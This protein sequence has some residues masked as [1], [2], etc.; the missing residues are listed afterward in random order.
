MNSCAQTLLG[1][2]S[3]TG[4]SLSVDSSNLSAAIR[5]L[6]SPLFIVNTSQGL[7]LA[8]GGTA[9]FG[10]AGHDPNQYPIM[11]VVPPIQLE[12]LGD[13]SFRHDHGLRFNYVSGAMAAGIGSE[14]IVEEMARHGMLGFFGSAGLS[15]SRV[16]S[17]IDR[18]E[19]LSGSYGFNLIHSPNEQSLEQS[20]VD[21]YLRRQVH[22]VEASAYLDLTPHV[23]RYRLHGIHR[24]QD[25]EVRTPNRVVAKVSRIEVGSKFFAP[26]PAKIL[27]YLVDQGQITVEQAKLAEQVPVA[28]DITAEADSGGHTDNRPA[29]TLLPTILAL[30][31]RAAAQY[32]FSQPLRVGA[33]GGISTPVSAAA[34]FAM[35]AAYILVGSVQQACVESGTCDAVRQMLAEAEQADVTMCPCADMFEMGVKVQVLKRGT[36]FPM[37]AAKLYETYRSCKGIE[38]IPAADRDWLEKNL[39]RT[40]LDDVWRQTIDYFSTRDPVQIEKG[41][42][43]SKHRMALV[44]RWYLGQ[45]SRWANSG[46][47]SRRLDYQI[48][49][50]PAMGAFNEW[51]RGTF[52]AQPANRSVATVAYNLLRG[53]AVAQRLNSLRTQG[54][55]VP[56][57]V[58]R[59]VPEE[60][61]NW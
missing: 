18:L 6:D 48:W 55:D 1:W 12:R 11:G 33:A 25:G 29:L 61:G 30:R 19:T 20:I 34:A 49:C 9:T 8:R 39:F 47:A 13:P 41:E 58:A 59:I 56:A 17:A 50:G 32:R 5:E 38:D 36:M 51:T 22:L 44:F 4:G 3:A 54:F 27:S 14:R 2:W 15:P 31:D 16:E 53:A 26:A 24:G 43:D 46:E 10:A 7:A 42:R 23:V 28:Q 57:E 45:S 60:V 40:T 35:G 21:L 37:R 52:L